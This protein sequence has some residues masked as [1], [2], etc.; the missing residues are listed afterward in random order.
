MTGSL[1]ITLLAAL[2]S[3]LVLGALAHRLGL[4]PMIG[5]IAA[6]LVVGPFTPGVVADPDEVL[7]LADI[8]VALLM[9]SIGLRFRIG[10]LREVG[11]LVLIGAPLQV[12]ITMGLGVAVM[13]ALGAGFVEA[14]FMGAVASICSSVVLVKVAGEEALSSTPDGRLALSW[15]IVQ[16]LLTVVLVVLLSAVAAPTEA[17]LR[18]AAVATLVALA[19]VGAVL[20][21]GS[22]V[23]PAVLGRVAML[24]S[25]ELFVVAVAVVAIGTA[26]VA[27][28]VG[29]SVAL[30]AFIAGLALAESDLA[31]SVLGE[32]IP[33]RELFATIFFVSVGILLSPA[34]IAAGWPIALSLLLVIVLGK[35]LPI[36]AIL[37]VAGQPFTTSLRTAGLLAQSGEF[38]FVLA[39]VG[40]QLGALDRDRFSLAMGA[41]VLSIVAAGPVARLAAAMGDGLER[42]FPAGGM[43]ESSEVAAG[44]RRHVVLVGYGVIGRT[45]GRML[46][47]R[48]I[49]WVA[50]D[51]DYP[52]VR[53]ALGAGTPLVYGDGA[54]PAVLDAA[55]ID[56]ASTLVI[57]LDDPL[58]TMQAAAYAMSRNERLYVLARAHSALEEAEL[59]R[60]GVAH[61]ITAERHLG[62][63][64]V[65]HT[66]VRYG[67]SE[68]EVDTILRRRA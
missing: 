47:A 37:R 7:A 4:A 61:V 29:V 50:I 1:A 40:L 46:E 15:S 59:R 54:T 41:V 57:A 66:L 22:R 65:R 51:A 27:H 16:D 35:A 3:A 25:R 10:E 34:A 58:A 6:G 68:R 36:A 13:L 63:E 56:A 24:G 5:Y 45:V 17:L 49:P 48:S 21:I 18:D 64:L 19:F 60:I 26:A 32:V 23:L 11:R 55:R 42:R 9:F 67:I 8:G 62:N 12:A 53:R 28:E 14:L 38:S 2:G 43:A 44:L 30:G 20:V 52:M 39:T 33:L 31:A